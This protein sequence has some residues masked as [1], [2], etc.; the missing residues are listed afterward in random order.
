M[1]SIWSIDRLQKYGLRLKIAL[2][3]DVNGSDDIKCNKAWSRGPI[4]IPQRE[5]LE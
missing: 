5:L 3:I 2:V 1:E 4:Y